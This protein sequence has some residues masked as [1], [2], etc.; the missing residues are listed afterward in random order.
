MDIWLDTLVNGQ[1][2]IFVQHEDGSIEEPCEVI[3]QRSQDGKTLHPHFNP[4]LMLSDK[5]IC[6][7]HGVEHVMY[8]TKP[9][10]DLHNLYI[11]A[12]KQFR[13]QRSGIIQPDPAKI[14]LIK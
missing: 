8:H 12:V 10:N 13:I 9:N 11:E 4:L 3:V 1:N 14:H 7:H 5:G 6:N 2:I